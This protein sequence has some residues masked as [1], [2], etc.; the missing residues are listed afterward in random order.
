MR[1]VWVWQ[2]QKELSQSTKAE[3]T[4]PKVVFQRKDSYETWEGI[5]PEAIY[6]YTQGWP[7]TREAL[8]SNIWLFIWRYVIAVYLTPSIDNQI[9]AYCEQGHAL[10]PSTAD[11][12]IPICCQMCQ[13][14]CEPVSGLSPQWNTTITLYLN[15]FISM[16]IQGEM[17]ADITLCIEI[18]FY[19]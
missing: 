11:M 2:P 17:M 12:V 19:P 4:A 7:S 18:I 6:Q 8:T 5:K 9:G 10:I 16:V 3:Q 13:S 15:A 1:K 14:S